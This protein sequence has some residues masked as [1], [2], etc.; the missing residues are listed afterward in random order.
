MVVT[1]AAA[2]AL[3]AVA[4]GWRVVLYIERLWARFLVSAH[5]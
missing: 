3:A 4:V 5:T 1:K 2:W